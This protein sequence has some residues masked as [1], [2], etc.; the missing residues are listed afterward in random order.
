[1]YD[2]YS[3]RRA[4]ERVGFSEVTLQSPDKS[5]IEDWGSFGLDT[6]PDGTVYKPGSLYMEALK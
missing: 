6:E 2:R 4:L 5:R 1:M 3:L